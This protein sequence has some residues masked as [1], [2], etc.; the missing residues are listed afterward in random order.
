MWSKILKDNILS[1]LGD[2][3]VRKLAICLRGGGPYSIDRKLG[4]ELWGGARL[5]YSWR[6]Y[7]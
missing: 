5:R 7:H 1:A 2:P 4:W 3:Q 6:R